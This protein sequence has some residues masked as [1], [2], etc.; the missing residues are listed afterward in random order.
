MDPGLVIGSSW[1]VDVEWPVRGLLSGTI[2]CYY[3]LFFFSGDGLGTPQGGV[4]RGLGSHP[5]LHPK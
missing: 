1:I 3:Y 2:H 5:G 4:P